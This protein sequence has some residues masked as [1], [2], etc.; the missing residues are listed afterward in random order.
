MSRSC[1][2]DHTHT[3]LNPKPN[4]SH[5]VSTAEEAA[6]ATT[7]AAADDDDEEDVMASIIQKQKE[8]EEAKARAAQKLNQVRTVCFGF[9]VC[10]T[11]GRSGL[12]V[13]CGCFVLLPRRG[14]L[15]VCVAKAAGGASDAHAR[16]ICLFNVDGWTGPLGLVHTADALPVPFPLSSRLP[17]LWCGIISFCVP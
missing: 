14:A 6:A 8:L 10:W 13:V 12:N 7:A 16:P 1:D 15:F 3:R 4:P 11:E 5:T 9:L 17:F 2:R